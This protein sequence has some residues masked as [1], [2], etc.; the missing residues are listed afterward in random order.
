MCCGSAAKT[1][2]SEMGMAS[3]IAKQDAQPCA[4][5]HS[6]AWSGSKSPCKS[7]NVSSAG[8]PDLTGHFIR[9]VERYFGSLIQLAAQ[10]VGLLLLAGVSLAQDPPPALAPLASVP[11]EVVA[12][13]STGPPARPVSRVLDQT[14]ALTAAERATLTRDFM[15]AA[16]DGLSLYFI[17]LNSSES[18][19]EEDA[20]AEL[21]RLWEDAPLTAVILH[22]PG[23]AMSLGF[24]GP[25]LPTFEQEEIAALIQSALAAGRARQSMPEQGKA[26]A[27]RLIEDFTRYRAGESPAELQAVPGMAGNEDDPARRLFLWGGS[28]G[29]VFLCGLLILV[30]RRRTLRP[31][32]F[33]LTAPRGRFSAPHSGGNNVMIKFPNERGEE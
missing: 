33:P 24:S 20:A 12:A 2:L 19:P 5:W 22:V 3:W 29:I 21:A 8:H 17:A 16:G 15:A 23:R 14:G 7:H 10:R 31:R 27:R 32:L 25:R 13:E 26:A 11:G 4:R 1:G 30:R 6:A 28:A 9:L 18:L